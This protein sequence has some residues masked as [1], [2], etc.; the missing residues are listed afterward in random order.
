MGQANYGL[1]EEM[2]LE[3]GPKAGWRARLARLGAH[4]R[5]YARGSDWLLSFYQRALL[6]LPKVPL[7]FRGEVRAVHLV[8][9]PGPLYVRL[10]TSD[11][12]VLEEVF[13]D[14]VYEPAT[15]RETRQLR[16][17]ID[18]GAN[19]GFSTLW[20]RKHYSEAEIIAVE[21]DREN[22]LMFARN[23][24]AQEDSEKIELV[25]ACVAGKSRKVA[26]DRTGGSWRFRMSDRDGVEAGDTEADEVVEALTLPQIMEEARVTGSIDLL[27]CDIE[28]AEAEVFAD[29]AAWIGRVRQLIVEVHR[30]YTVRALLEDLAHGGG[31]F[32]LYHRVAAPDGSQLVFLEQL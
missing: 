10:N 14:K 1:E 6:R 25:R 7:P 30:P 29:C 24:S 17:I 2:K 13:L 27:K 11:W 15:R 5:Q 31:R 18:L 4:R 32:E 28:G 21:P 26:L 22:S 16:H 12:Y 19:T 8:S 23:V 9:W 20:W 3:P